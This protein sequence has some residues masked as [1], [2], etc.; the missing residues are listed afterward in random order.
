MHT[1]RKKQ[2]SRNRSLNRRGS[3]RGGD[4]GTPEKTQSRVELQPGQGHGAS[5][6]E[7]DHNVHANP[8]VMAVESKTIAAEPSQGH[9]RSWSE[10]SRELC[11]LL[12]LREKHVCSHDHL[13]E[14]ESLGGRKM[15]ILD[16]Q[17]HHNVQ[18]FSLLSSL[19][20]EP[21][22]RQTENSGEW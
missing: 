16:N 8:S 10:E 17:P 7:A 6:L 1:G 20:K 15:N 3:K 22:Y 13:T 19:G 12:P 5:N 21:Q 9:I 2:K 4:G 14:V 18:C 11:P